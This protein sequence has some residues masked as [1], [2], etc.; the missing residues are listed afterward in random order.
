MTDRTHPRDMTEPYDLAHVRDMVD[1]WRG[2]P[3]R[4]VPKEIQL[5][6]W[7]I[8]QLEL[9]SDHVERR[10]DKCRA[11]EELLESARTKLDS[12]PL[13]AVERYN[14]IR[15]DR[16]IEGMEYKP[17]PWAGTSANGSGNGEQK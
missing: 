7:M 1:S 15:R 16:A 8:E 11:I 5:I 3:K 12:W 10:D 6:A 2:I 13:E 9:L 4:K 17:A 14:A